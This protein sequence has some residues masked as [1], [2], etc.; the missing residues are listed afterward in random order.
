MWATS[1]PAPRTPRAWRSV[2][3]KS[4]RRRSLEPA[5]STSVR[6][7]AS[8]APWRAGSRGWRDRR[9]CACAG[10][11]R[12]SWPDGDCWAG[13][14]AC[15]RGGSRT[16]SV[17]HVC[18]VAVTVDGRRLPGTTDR[19]AGTPQQPSTTRPGNGTGGLGPRSNL[20]AFQV[21]ARCTASTRHRG[22]SGSVSRVR[23]AGPAATVVPVREKIP[24][25]VVDNRLLPGPHVV[26]V[27]P[28]RTAQPDFPRGHR[29][30]ISPDQVSRC[31]MGNRD[32]TGQPMYTGCGRP[33]GRHIRGIAGAHRSD[34]TREG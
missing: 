6:P 28:R 11:S 1:S 34:R 17:V 30:C 22:T 5:G 14:C 31:G 32:I 21:T 24:V 8:C 20:A 4:A 23:R 26:S 7:R 29:P 27:S 15:S 18:R 19:K 25:R 3:V 33:C 2:E 10:G 12:G 16:A 9:G 13:T